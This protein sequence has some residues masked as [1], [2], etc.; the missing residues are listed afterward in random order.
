MSV[1]VTGSNGFLGA[2][3]VG[4]LLARGEPEVRCFV[5]PGGERSRLQ[6]VRQQYSEERSPLVE[7]SLGSVEAAAAA[8]AG[9]DTIYHLAAGLRGTPADM[10][11]NTVVASK[12]LLEAV[13]RSSK[14]PK[15]VL[16]SSFGVYGVADLSA[17]ALV[18]EST[19]LEA[20]PTWRDSYSQTKLRQE[21]LFWQYQREHDLQLVVLRPGVIYGPGNSGIS[22]RIGL[23]LPGLFLYLGRDNPLPL[24]YVDNCAEALA[25]AGSAPQAVGQVYNVHDDDLPTCREYFDA[26][27]REVSALRYVPVPYPALLGLS[28]LVQRYHHFSKGQLPAVFTPYKTASS[29]KGNR[30]SNAK[31]KA[32][33]WQQLVTTEEGMRRTFEYQR[34]AAQSAA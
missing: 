15:I 14:R 12:N 26:F 21:Q 3:L 27:R 2:A 31:L 25:V 8:I 1:L 28:T 32:L 22:A 11:L 29:W 10:C 17:G 19:P 9:V 18:D 6:E 4:R 33:G 7:G 13:V 34:A 16:V 30:F 24:S 23:Q 5:R 20:N